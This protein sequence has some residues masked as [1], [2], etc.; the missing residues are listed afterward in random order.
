MIKLSLFLITIDVI[1]FENPTQTAGDTTAFVAQVSP[2][3]DVKGVVNTIRNCVA[4][5]NEW[6]RKEL[7]R[8]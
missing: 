6:N 7:N 4:S 1:S 8:T 2:A 5:V 3:S